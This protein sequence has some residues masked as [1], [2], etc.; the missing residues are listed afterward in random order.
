MFNF[1][2]VRQKT[3]REKRKYFFV[4]SQR[5]KSFFF[6]I[7]ANAGISCFV[8]RDVRLRRLNDGHLS[9]ASNKFKQVVYNLYPKS[10]SF[11][12]HLR[13][14]SGE[15]LLTE[16]TGKRLTFL[17]PQASNTCFFSTNP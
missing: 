10:Y 12:S 9:Y 17:N 2:K 4:L 16:K 5:R 7:P 3:I 1:V 8:S 11:C 14:F 6:V 13:R 15:L